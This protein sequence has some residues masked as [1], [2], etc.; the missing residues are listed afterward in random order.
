MSQN[1][2]V[3]AIVKYSVSMRPDENRGSYTTQWKGVHRNSYENGPDFRRRGKWTDY[4]WVKV[5]GCV[6]GTL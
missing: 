2:T 3:L 6:Y 5:Q 4:G 1:G